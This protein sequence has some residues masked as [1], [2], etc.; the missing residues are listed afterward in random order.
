MVKV[1]Y[2]DDEKMFDMPQS[3]I[4]TTRRRPSVSLLLKI[5]LEKEMQLLSTHRADAFSHKKDTSQYFWVYHGVAV[6]NPP[7]HTFL[8]NMNELE[9]FKVYQI[10]P[11]IQDEK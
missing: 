1:F 2:D 9:R 5:A 10:F 4:N 3:H 6:D 8:S 11:F 7:T